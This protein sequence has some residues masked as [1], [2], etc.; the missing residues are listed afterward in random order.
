MMATSRIGRSRAARVMCSRPYTFMMCRL[1]DGSSR[2]QASAEPGPKLFPP[3]AVHA[4]H[5]TGTIDV[6]T[7]SAAP[8]LQCRVELAGQLFAA[9]HE[10]CQV[11]GPPDALLHGLNL[12][13]LVMPMDVAPRYL[14]RARLCPSKPNNDPRNNTRFSVSVSSWI[15]LMLRK[16]KC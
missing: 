11:A 10:H 5:P 7:N 14:I 6:R 4:S 13:F 2:L 16:Q 15:V 12:H 9:S 1:K 8:A 3:A